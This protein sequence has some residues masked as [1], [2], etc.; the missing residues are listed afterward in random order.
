MYQ[1]LSPFLA[2]PLPETE[3]ASSNASRLQHSTLTRTDSA[4]P[5]GQRR[6]PYRCH[7]AAA[8]PPVNPVRI[9]QPAP[10]APESGSRAAETLTTETGQTTTS[11]LPQYPSNTNLSAD[12]PHPSIKI[13][14]IPCC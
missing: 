2:L 11:S 12:T 1:P 13:G 14:G 4:L 9:R 6:R 3:T 8:G 10:K 5:A 7:V